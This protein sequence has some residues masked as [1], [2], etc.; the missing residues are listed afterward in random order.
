MSHP[1][2]LIAVSRR[3]DRPKRLVIISDEKMGR[4]E[5]AKD[6]GGE[7]KE[8]GREG[9]ERERKERQENQRD[10]RKSMQNDKYMSCILHSIHKYTVCTCTC[11]I[12]TMSFTIGS[13]PGYMHINGVCT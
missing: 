9:R 8:G 7:G 5:G 4:E 11:K 12:H 13:R 6:S 2:Q 1:E 3:S 10:T